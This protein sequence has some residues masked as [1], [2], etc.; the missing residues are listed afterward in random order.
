MVG[1][2]GPEHGL[3]RQ[4]SHRLRRGAIGAEGAARHQPAADFSLRNCLP[5]VRLDVS[6]VPR[7]GGMTLLTI[8]SAIMAA[9][10]GIVLLV[11]GLAVLGCRSGPAL[12]LGTWAGCCRLCQTVKPVALP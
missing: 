5:C 7:T 4:F 2:W 1:I 12:C 10:V 8:A 6:L 9:V 3:C 11:I